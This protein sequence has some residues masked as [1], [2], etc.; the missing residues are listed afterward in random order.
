MALKASIAI[1]LLRLTVNQIHR[2]II[3]IC[4]GVTEIYGLFFFFL[5][6]LQCRPSSYFW[7]QYTGGKGKCIDP[8]IT[9]NAT[10]AYSAISCLS[11]WIFAILPCFMV[12]N[13][14]MNSRTKVSVALILG[15]GAM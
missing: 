3:W 11:D 14:K 7:T 1:M 10:Y 8:Q 2:W 15:M 13:L 5:F 12:W 4:L 6:V 9:V